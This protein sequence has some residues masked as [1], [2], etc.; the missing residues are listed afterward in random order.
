MD[1]VELRPRPDLNEKVKKSKRFRSKEKNCAL[2]SGDTVQSMFFSMVL[3]MWFGVDPGVMMLFHVLVAVSRIY[4]MCHWIGDTIAA[5][6]MTIPLG[7]LFTMARQ[8][9]HLK[10]TFYQIVGKVIKI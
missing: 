2:P 6:I 5:T 8:D 1:A 9:P 3:V 4:F 7:V 10:D